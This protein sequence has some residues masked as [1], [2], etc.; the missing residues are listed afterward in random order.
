MPAHSLRLTAATVVVIALFPSVSRPQSRSDTDPAIVRLVD[1]IS[2]AR[3]EEA[4]KKLVSFG[5]RDA[6]NASPASS[7]RGNQAA[8][9]WI[10]EQLRTASPR[11]QVS[12]D[13]HQLP[14]NQFGG[15]PEER[16]LRNV[17]AVLPGR[18][19]RRIYVTAH[20]DSYDAS[21]GPDAAAPG[22]DDNGSGTVL[23]M[24]LARVFA[25]S[26]LAFDATIVFMATSAEEQ[27]L[28]GARLH[29]TRMKG[30]GI[31]IQAVFNN[32]I[33]GGIS[34]SSGYIDRSSVRVFSEEPADSPSR[35]LAMFVRSVAAR[36]VPS[37]RVRLIARQDRLGRSSD[38]LAF[39][40]A[41]LPVPAIGF[42]ESRE[43]LSRQ[44]NETDTLD[45]ISFPYLAQNARVNA[46]AV[47][48]LA[49]APL[50]PVLE[51]L[52]ADPTSAT[53]RLRWKMVPN[54]IGYRVYWRQAWGP[55]WEQN[56]R[57]GNV[58]EY[59]VSHA[60]ADD[61]I[62]GIAAIGRDNHESPISAFLAP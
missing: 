29:A 24:E 8:G 38:H 49:L 23:L 5:T 36:Y 15:I 12:Y 34:D 32:D 1:A 31:P 35:S 33:V 42:R 13:V 11:L 30:T 21:K 58:T 41:E 55:D 60:Q 9:E 44:H 4:L 28:L 48:E 37:Q 25:S 10:Y 6:R 17:L 18:S 47:A 7:S 43:D 52:N 2:P 27:G 61:S 59:N 19:P 14:A 16:E 39:A 53:V 51:F 45:R 54:A 22:A 57:V 40:R 46:A 3:L 50:P 26:P 20:Y 62:F 56:I